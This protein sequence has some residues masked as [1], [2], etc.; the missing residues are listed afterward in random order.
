MATPGLS[1]GPD[2]LL[3]L[4]RSLGQGLVQRLG[5]IPFESVEKSV[6]DLNM[7]LP[8]IESDVKKLF[9]YI[10]S[11]V[12]ARDVYELTPEGFKQ[13]RACTK[14]MMGKW[15]IGLSQSLNLANGLLKLANSTITKM[16]SVAIED[17]E[18]IVKLKDEII[19][20]KNEQLESV[21]TTV[22]SEMKTYADLF[23]KSCKKATVT[24]E[25]LTKAIK[26]VTEEEDRG[27]NLMIFGLVEDN[28]ECLS[29]K[30]D[31]LFRSVGEKPCIQDCVR[32]GK[33]NTDKETTTVSV[34]PVK[35]IMR[36]PDTVNQLLW[37]SG[38]LK[39]LEIYKS[40]YFRPDRT[41]E[42]RAT[43]QQLVL[44]MKE[45]IKDDPTNYHYIKNGTIM[46]KPKD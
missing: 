24:Q 37:K 11:E 44:K 5:T 12:G 16:Q 2:N 26:T 31:E 27:K 15:I 8:V 41:P 21:S 32:V 30:V 14:T 6:K 29:D 36:S 46:S 10:V 39:G 4:S 34:R 3:D 33:T 18:T 35:V 28:G 13:E 20:T 38:K 9:P 7:Y 25:K 17:K 1:R 19:A 43:H 40:V 23:K 45:K 42:D 22:Q